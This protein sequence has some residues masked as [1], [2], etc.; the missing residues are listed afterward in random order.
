[1]KKRFSSLLLCI[2]GAFF[3]LLFAGCSSTDNHGLSAKNPTNIKVWHYYN[4]ALATAFDAL[5]S[6]FNNTVGRENGIVVYS[7]SM[8]TVSDLENALWDSVNE[9]VGAPDMPNVFQCYQDTATALDEVISLVNLDDYVTEKERNAY[10]KRFLDSGRVGKDNAW[11]LFPIAKSTEVLILN[12]TDWDKFAAD[13]GV[14]TQDLTTWEA[15]ADTAEKYYTWSGGKAFFGRDAFAN[16]PIIASSQ[17]GHDIFQVSDGNTTLDFDK[18]AMRK[19]WDYFYVPYV[20]GYYRHVGQYRSDDVKIGEII[21]LVCSSSSAAYFPTEVTPIDGPSYPIEHLVLP[22]PNFDGMEPYAVQQGA[23][24]AVTKS[25]ETQE[26]ASVVFLKWFTEWQQNLKFSI[27]SGYMPVSVEG[28]KI[29]TVDNY[30]ADNPA[31]DMIRDTL[32]VAL[33]E[34]SRYVMYTPDAFT[35]GTQARSVL[36]TTLPELAIQD[37]AAV[38]GGASIDDFLTDEHFDDWYEDTL[39]QLKEYCR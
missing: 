30:L 2:C 18:D 32:H 28:V 4:G 33:D 3:A 39:A 24:M 17:L 25:T 27:N 9:K 19:I 7:E 34:N 8:S 26:Y 5:V 16:Y 20:K 15:L 21:A 29:E 36:D 13:T 11:K 23:G 1:M 6:E 37:R 12:K 35:G 38:E 14:T 31:S 10:V 22:L